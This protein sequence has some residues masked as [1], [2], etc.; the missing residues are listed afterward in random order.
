MAHTFNPRTR[1]KRQREFEAKLGLQS[2][3]EFIQGYEKKPCLEK[4]KTKKKE[5]K[6][7]KQKERDR[8]RR[9]HSTAQLEATPSPSDST[10]RLEARTQDTPPVPPWPT[11]RGRAAGGRLG[12]GRVPAGARN[13][14]RGTR[15]AQQVIS[16][17][18]GLSH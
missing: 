2:E 14:G 8:K 13:P 3:F 9:S 18:S 6:K 10:G 4:T 17:G 5:E 16:S 12:N 11:S 1:E 15:R 7:E